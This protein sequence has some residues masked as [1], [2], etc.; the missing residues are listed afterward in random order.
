MT[1]PV[2]VDKVRGRVTQ[3][4]YGEGTKSERQ[5]IFIDTADGRFI[6]RTK[7]GPAYGDKNLERYVGHDVECDGFLVGASLLAE[8]V[9]IQK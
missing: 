4:R 5:A 2:R 9:E 7:T 6:L 3:G 8:R 1:T